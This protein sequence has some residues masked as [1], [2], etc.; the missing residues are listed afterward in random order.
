MVGGC[1]AKSKIAVVFGLI[2]LFAIIYPCKT[3]GSGNILLAAAQVDCRIGQPESKG[4]GKQAF[5][6]SLKLAS[7][8]QEASRSLTQSTLP[9]LASL[10]PQ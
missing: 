8:P 6:I 10:K 7:S 4:I 9:I 5:G 2:R 3:N 1:V